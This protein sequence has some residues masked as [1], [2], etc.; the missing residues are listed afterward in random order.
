[1]PSERIPSASVLSSSYFTRQLFS[2]NFCIRPFPHRFFH[3]GHS[4]YFLCSINERDGLSLPTEKK[5]KKGEKKS[6]QCMYTLELEPEI[7]KILVDPETLRLEVLL[8]WIALCVYI[9]TK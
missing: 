6:T 9:A 1:M 8:A 3:C 5:K 4:Y 2:P 7:Y